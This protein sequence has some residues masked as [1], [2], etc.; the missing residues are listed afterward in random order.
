MEALDMATDGF[1]LSPA[2]R[3]MDVFNSTNGP[4]TNVLTELFREGECMMGPHVHGLAYRKGDFKFMEGIFQD[5]NYYYES[6]NLNLNTSDSSSIYAKVTEF[7]ITHTEWM[8]GKGPFD[9]I[10]GVISIAFLQGHYIK[11]QGEGQ[12]YLFNVKEDPTE[13]HNLADLL[14]SVVAEL[15]KDV[16]AIKAKLPKQQP[17]WLVIP[18]E[19]YLASR[20]KGDCSMNPNIPPGECLFHH[21]YVADDVKDSEIHLIDDTVPLVERIAIELVLIPAAKVILPVLVLAYYAKTFIF[22]VQL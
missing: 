20:V 5:L 13:S 7:I 11:Q 6:H 12:T 9:T 16:E 14:P 10:R 17:Y 19:T 3:S 18:E 21:P 2:L 4:R 15:R 1:D 22:A 8:F